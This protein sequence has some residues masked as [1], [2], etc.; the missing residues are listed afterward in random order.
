MNLSV[1]ERKTMAALASARFW[2]DEASS[3][4]NRRIRINMPAIK[5]DIKKELK[6]YPRIEKGIINHVAPA[7]RR[8][9]RKI[10]KVFK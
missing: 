5:Q 6:R 3:I 1:D 7:V 4:A 9:I 2:R 8:T 10:R